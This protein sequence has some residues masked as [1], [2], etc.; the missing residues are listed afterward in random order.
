MEKV[1]EPSLGRHL[2]ETLRNARDSI[3]R[4]MVVDW[5]L[6]R[7]RQAVHVRVHARRQKGGGA[8]GD[9]PGVTVQ[10][11]THVYL[12]FY[13]R[14]SK[15]AREISLFLKYP[16]PLHAIQRLEHS[17]LE[18]VVE[19]KNGT[20]AELQTRTPMEL[21]SEYQLKGTAVLADDEIV[22]QFLPKHAG[23][24]TVRIFADTRELCR[25]VSFRVSR[26]CEIEAIP[27]D[28]PVKPAA[29]TLLPPAT[30]TTYD[31][32]GG[33]HQPQFQ[34]QYHHSNPMEQQ[35]Q[36]LQARPQS[37]SMSSQQTS[38][39]P[40]YGLGY[41]DTIRGFMSD[42]SLSTARQEPGG[43]QRASFITSQGNSRP[44]SM[45]LAD[46]A[47]PGDLLSSKPDQSTFDQ[48]YAAK[49][50][51]HPVY[52]TRRGVLTLD[53]TSAITEGALRSLHKDIDLQVASHLSRA[54]I[55]RRSAV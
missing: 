21:R 39:Q 2:T 28:R 37:P 17:F 14:N 44:S 4:I 31:Y 20:E 47:Y 45:V 27:S 5:L 55:K 8:H 43:I 30:T 29:Q 33:R 51:G 52:G 48:I 25:P 34:A 53:H 1:L 32:T 41:G 49:R 16:G 38:N 19:Y 26:A 42:P 7:Y 9:S 18:C 13:V 50:A 36:Q 12:L 46:S 22:V 35:Q 10:S 40:E 3:L 54:K 24:H 6:N 15:M 23:I 11:P